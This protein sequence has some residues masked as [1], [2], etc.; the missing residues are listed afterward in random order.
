MNA[1]NVRDITV[2]RIGNI[3]WLSID[4]MIPTNNIMAVKNTKNEI[5]NIL[6]HFCVFILGVL[7]YVLNF[8]FPPP[9]CV[10][11]RIFSPKNQLQIGNLRVGIWL[12]VPITPKACISSA[13]CCGISSMRSIVSH[14]A[15]GGCTLA[16]DEIQPQRGWWYTPHFVRQ[17]Y[18]KP[19]AW[20]K[21]SSFRRT[22]IF[23]RR[24]RDSNPRNGISVHTISNRA[25]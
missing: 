3:L 16:R 1:T 6:T 21:K 7:S 20:I 13:T 19:A 2:M 5:R 9:F 8:I 12:R 11:Y 25:P 17:W 10:Y 22:R 18:T 24:E 15:A 4:I 23:W 14:Q